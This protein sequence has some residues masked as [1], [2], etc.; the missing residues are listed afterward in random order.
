MAFSPNL[1]DRERDKFVESPSR[2]G[3]SAVE[4]FGTLTSSSGP[5]SPPAGANAIVR[6]VAG[7]VETYQYKSGGIAGTVLKTITVTSTDA[8]LEEL[9]TVEV[10]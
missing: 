3:M 6:S 7:A 8:T 1:E 5:F 2:S 4:V 9:L 10:S